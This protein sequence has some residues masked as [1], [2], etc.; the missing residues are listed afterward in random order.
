MGSKITLRVLH[1]IRTLEGGGMERSMVALLN[2]LD[3]EGA[4]HFVVTLRDAG[5]LA[6]ELRDDVACYAMRAKGRSWLTGPKLAR[7]AR[8]FGATVIHARGVGCWADALVARL[9]NPR[10]RLVLGF[11]GF[12]AGRRFSTWHRCI[13]RCAL[14]ADATFASVSSAGARQLIEELGVPGER[15]RL[16]ANGVR[17]D[18]FERVNPGD[19]RAIRTSLGI[20]ADAFVLGTLGSLTPVK[21]YD[22]VIDAAARLADRLPDL[23]VL[24]VGDGRL[25]GDFER[26]ARD[27]GVG[28]RVCFAGER[29]DVPRMLAAMDVYVCSSDSEGMSNALLEAM[30]AGL[31]IVATDVGDNAQIVRD[32]V[33]GR[34]VPSGS[35][36]AIAEAVAFLAENSDARRKLGSGARA[37]ADAFDFSRTLRAYEAFYRTLADLPLGSTVGSTSGRA[38]VLPT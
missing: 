33:G 22:L 28:G 1:V 31:P 38:H 32:G 30:A 3:R 7:V 9:L 27:A 2:A 35:A 4:S 15:I 13:A 18:D 17:V 6:A 34:V 29:S 23:R 11:H 24:M 5:A 14:A 19:R 8:T 10:V 21:R 26:R 16:L 36:D 12:E 25:R 37:G 20:D